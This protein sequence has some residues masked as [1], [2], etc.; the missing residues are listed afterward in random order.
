MSDLVEQVHFATN[1]SAKAAYYTPLAQKL[2]P[3]AGGAPQAPLWANGSNSSTRS[4]IGVRSTWPTCHWPAGGTVKQIT[5][6]IRSSTTQVLLNA[7]SYHAWLSELAVGW[8]ALPAAPLDYASVQEAKLVRCGLSYL[9]LSWSDRDWRLYQVVD[10]T[11]LVS[12]AKVVS[13]D[14]TGI[15]LSTPAR[16]HGCRQA[17]VVA[18]SDGARS[19]FGRRRCPPCVIDASGWVSLVVP[20]AETVELASQFDP[21]A[22]LTSPDPDCASDVRNK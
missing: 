12:G 19:E 6:I 3:G 7:D 15:V 13:V 1:P 9:R 20:H 4:T 11:P 14:S 18:V 10:A 8:V 22:R 2:D 16:G 21:R 17:A 5:L